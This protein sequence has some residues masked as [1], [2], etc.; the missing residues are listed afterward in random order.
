MGLSVERMTGSK[1]VF[2]FAGMARFVDEGGPRLAIFQTELC[3]RAFGEDR[4]ELF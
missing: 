1:E 3:V 2:V 4:H